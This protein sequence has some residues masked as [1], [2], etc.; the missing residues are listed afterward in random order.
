MDMDLTYPAEAEQ[1]RKEVRTWLE[2]NLP[3][4][5][6]SDDFDMAPDERAAF[7]EAWPQKLFEGELLAWSAERLNLPVASA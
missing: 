2:D 7:N 1:Y 5:W 4:G 6:G 3:D